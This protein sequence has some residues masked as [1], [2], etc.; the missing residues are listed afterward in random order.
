MEARARGSR[1]AETWSLLGHIPMLLMD[2]PPENALLVG[3]G[4]GI[5]LG[6]MESY[7]V[8]KVDVVELEPAVVEAAAFFA[9]SNNHALT[10]PR[11][12][13]HISDGRNFV[14]TTEETYDVIISAVSDPWITG[15][16]NL[17][18]QE[19]FTELKEKLIR[20]RHGCALV[21]ELQ[22]QA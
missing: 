7:P 14:F 22:D 10:D 13:L 2:R 5:T 20:R 19:Y 6:A 4:S 1:P 18:T 21:S 11:T 3:L 12:N 8:R 9:E 15:V 16:S 17:F